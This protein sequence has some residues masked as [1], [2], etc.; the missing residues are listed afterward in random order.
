MF[1]QVA[2]YVCRLSILVVVASMPIALSAQVVSPTEK[3]PQGNIAARWD[4]FAGYSYLRPYGTV[5]TR[6]NYTVT[7][8]F[9]FVADRGQVIG[10]VARY[11]TRHWGLELVGDVH[12]QNDNPYP[13]PFR[14]VPRNSFSGGLGGVIFRFRNSSS[15]PFIH[16]LLGGEIADGPHY[17]DDHWGPVGTVG[18]GLDCE[19]SLFRHHMA[20][21]LI[22]ADYQRVYEDWGKGMSG[23]IGNIDAYR[24]SAGAVFHTNNGDADRPVLGLACLASKS[25]IYPGEPVTLTATASNLNSRQS[26]IYMWSGVGVSGSG[27]RATVATSSLGPGVYTVKAQVQEAKGTR[28]CMRVIPPQV[29]TCTASYTVK[30]F[31]PPTISCLASPA[32][33]KPGGTSTITAVGVSPQNRPLTYSYSASGGTVTGSGT[34]AVFNS[35]GAPTGSVVI[36]CVVTDDTGQMATSSAS[37]TILEPYVPPIQHSSALCSINFAT[38]KKRP[39]Y[40]NNEAKACLDEVALDLEKQPDARIVVVGSSDATEKAASERQQKAALANKRIKA[41]D[42]AAERAVNAKQYLVT[43]KG[44][45]AARISVATS[46]ANRRAAQNYLVPSGANF[47]ADVPATTPVDETAVKAAPR[48][49]QPVAHQKPAAAQKPAQPAE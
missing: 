23:G 8:P 29:A 46:A 19:T 36:P 35:A 6:L 21:R 3:A 24:L 15:T 27:D 41:E 5:E 39:S 44:I 25:E 14:Y 38:D 40:V 28:D 22:Q 43:E 10:S 34:S 11:Y 31:E 42:T 4:I 18:G 1:A 17:Q 9:S 32:T 13:K 12:L 30:R 48:K 49:P 47:T 26:L 2:K 16:A 7:E 33:I 37:V 45:D 20:I